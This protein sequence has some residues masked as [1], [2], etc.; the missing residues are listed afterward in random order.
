MLPCSLQTEAKRWKERGKQLFKENRFN[1]LVECYSLAI[2]YAPSSDRELLTQLLCNRSLVYIK[3]KTYRAALLDAEQ[4]V[5]IR[6]GW[7]KVSL[8]APGFRN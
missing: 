7:S 6:P 5:K 4:C 8:W 3:N 1:L 2:N